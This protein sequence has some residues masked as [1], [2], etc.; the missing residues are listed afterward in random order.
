MLGETLLEGMK[1]AGQLAAQLSETGQPPR[2]DVRLS[3]ELPRRA[4]E[5]A[6]RDTAQLKDG[7]QPACA[8]LDEPLEGQKPS[9]G[10]LQPS[11]LALGETQ[12]TLDEPPTP[13]L[14]MDK[15]TPA[16]KPFSKE[17][18]RPAPTQRC[19]DRW[20]SLHRVCRPVQSALL[21]APPMP[22]AMTSTPSATGGGP[23]VAASAQSAVGSAPGTAAGAPSAAAS[24]PNAE[25]S[26]PSATAGAPSATVG[27]PSAAAGAPSAAASALSAVGSEP[28]AAVG[29][30]SAAASAPSAI[31]NAPGAAAGVPNATASAPSTA[32]GAPSAAA[33][34]PSAVGSAPS[35][36]GSALS[37]AAG[38]AP[39]A[40]RVGAPAKGQ[41][42]LA[43]N[44]G[45]QLA[46][47]AQLRAQRSTCRKSTRAGDSE[48]WI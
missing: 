31:G 40:G 7:F 13:S 15:P 18:P 23:G 47:R 26:V 30:P 6:K 24:T 8:R 39:S 3:R 29:A 35:A 10:E 48:G 27:A 5:I 19:C 1:A 46:Y 36:K 41:G 20:Q 12:G 43:R 21:G 28:G 9:T 17:M 2:G 25:A 44:L 45:L 42:R 37:S 38:S 16:F 14:W 33:S 34:A 11:V 4:N 22:G 32:A